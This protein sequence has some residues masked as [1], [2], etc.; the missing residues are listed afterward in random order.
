MRGKVQVALDGMELHAISES[1]IPQGVDEGNITVNVTQTGKGAGYGQ[2]VTGVEDRTRDVTVRFVLKCRDTE[3]RAEVLDAINRWAVGEHDMTVSYRPGK[4]LRVL[5]VTPI[6]VQYVG[7][8][9]SEYKVGFRAI[10]IPYWEDRW[11]V[12]AAETASA[13]T[14]TEISIINSGSVEACLQLRAV[15]TG[16]ATGLKVVSEGQTM[17]IT[18]I[19][20]AA[21]GDIIVIDY[22]A[23][24]IQRIARITTNETVSLL[25]KRT[26]ASADDIVL[27][28]GAHTVTVKVTGAGA[29]VTAMIRRRWM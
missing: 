6:N 5:C 21:S 27:A 13:G 19:T 20:G 15:L 12:T 26:E 22:D 18:G 17:E 9:T 14:D 1:I 23:R 10:E 4:K 3:E 16:A 24:G 2:R 28:P 8:W 11:P 25:G 29:D 7:K